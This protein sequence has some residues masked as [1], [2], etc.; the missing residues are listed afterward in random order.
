MSNHDE[1]Q[2]LARDRAAARLLGQ[3]PPPPVPADLAARIVQTATR[4]PQ[5][6]AYADTLPDRAPATALEAAPAAARA[7]R[8]WL[9]P[10]IGTAV[11]AC[12]IAALVLHQPAE[13]TRAVAVAHVA[14]AD[15]PRV[16][17]IAPVASAVSLALAA[18]PKAAPTVS[19]SGAKGDTGS[20]KL[21]AK[22]PLRQAAPPVPDQ[23][24]PELA[25]VEGQPAPEPQPAPPPIRQAIVGPPNHTG[26]GSPILQTGPTQGLGISGSSLSGPGMPGSGMAGAPSPG[27]ASPGPGPGMPHFR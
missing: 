27:V 23:A 3:L 19:T 6:P 15:P 8:G 10:A 26:M 9:A 20:R 25:Q 18:P 16:V 12:A 24:V 21:P 7:R 4:L 14:P 5:H 17:I 2:E 22:P 11:A 13:P 1:E